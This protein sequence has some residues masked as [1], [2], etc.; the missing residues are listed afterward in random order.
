MKLEEAKR[1]ADRLTAMRV[2]KVS[3]RKKYVN[4]VSEKK[5]NKRGTD[6][7]RVR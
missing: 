5:G 4:G 2:S 1:T 6:T 7:T 3:E